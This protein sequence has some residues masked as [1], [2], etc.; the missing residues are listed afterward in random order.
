MTDTTATQ[1]APAA[2][3]PLDQHVNTLVSRAT[4]AYLLGSA[5]ADGAR[6]EGAVVRALLTDAIR[7]LGQQDPKEY[8]RRI[9][10]GE[11]ALR[12]REAERQ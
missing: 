6:G 3:A 5:E 9:V 7:R 10:M 11:A 2:G 1:V 8:E 12:R 4:R